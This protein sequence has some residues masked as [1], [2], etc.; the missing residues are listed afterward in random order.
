MAFP[1][2]LPPRPPRRELRSA[3]GLLPYLATCRLRGLYGVRVF[4]RLILGQG[5]DERR[6]QV[7]REHVIDLLE[8][9]GGVTAEAFFDPGERLTGSRRREIGERPHVEEL[10]WIGFPDLVPSS[11]MRSW[12]SWGNSPTSSVFVWGV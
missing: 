3:T 5:H 6:P 8:G 9:C 2:P 11:T 4:V 10:A 1:M 7:V 12:W